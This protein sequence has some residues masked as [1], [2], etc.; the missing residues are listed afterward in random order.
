M[1]RQ[2][3]LLAGFLFLLTSPTTH[4]LLRSLLIETWA[5]MLETLSIESTN[6]NIVDMDVDEVCPDIYLPVVCDYV[7]VFDN[8][9]LAFNAGYDN[10]FPWF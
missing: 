7:C 10:C 1:F 2:R 8:D 4:A 3:Q 5:S 6:C 9:C